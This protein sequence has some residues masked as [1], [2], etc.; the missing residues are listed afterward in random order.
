MRSTR[1]LGTVLVCMIGLVTADGCKSNTKES[2]AAKPAAA[3][4]TP[5]PAKPADPTVWVTVEDAL[6]DNVSE[7]AWVCTCYDGGFL[8]GD[9]TIWDYDCCWGTT[10]EYGSCGDSAT[11][12]PDTFECYNL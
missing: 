2:P 3:P 10:H 7:G 4:A 5:Q 9:G 11:C 6:C 1:I 12:D 8:S